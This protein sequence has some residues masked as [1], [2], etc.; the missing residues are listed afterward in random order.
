MA[1]YPKKINDPTEAALSAI[2]EAL[3]VN[4]EDEQS[5]NAAVAGPDLFT[6]PSEGQQE[7]AGAGADALEHA[8]V[9]RIVV[10]RQRYADRDL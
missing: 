10:L 6:A 3:H 9:E 1:N 8:D 4:E 2:Q 5:A 7:P